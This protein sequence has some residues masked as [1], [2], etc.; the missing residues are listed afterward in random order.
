MA[1]ADLPSSA[2]AEVRRR[3]RIQRRA[4]AVA[5]LVAASVATLTALVVFGD[6]IP[7]PL[8]LAMPILLVLVAKLAGL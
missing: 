5:D 3:E 4:L 7:T 2:P 6:E 1:D 8:V